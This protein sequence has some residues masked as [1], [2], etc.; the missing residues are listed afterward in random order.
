MLAVELSAS[1]M[2]NYPFSIAAGNNSTIN[3][4]CYANPSQP[5]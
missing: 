3:I 5:L 1:P 2:T 4:L